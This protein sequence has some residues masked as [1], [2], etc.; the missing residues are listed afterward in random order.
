[1]KRTLEDNVI[2]VCVYTFMII[3]FIVT[4]Y[5]FFYAFIISF[6]DGLDAARGGVYLWPRKFSLENYE[7]IF[8]DKSLIAGFGVTIARTIVGTIISLTFT[9]L[10]AFGLSHNN[11]YFKKAYISM[12]IFAM[13]FS[14]GLI[15][16]FILLRSLGLLDTFWV[17]VIPGMIVPF[18]AIIMMSFFR[19][20]PAALEE[21]ARIDGANDLHIFIKIIVPVSLPVFATIALFAGV[22]HWNSWFD[23]AYFT[24]K[25]S[26]KTASYY[27]KELINKAN[28]TSVSAAGTIQTRAELSQQ[29]FTAE[30]IRMCTLIVVVLPII[31]VY[32]FLQKYFVKGVMIGSVKG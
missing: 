15:P 14:G 32:P 7:A 17:Y 24:Q 18:N 1:M 31:C 6:N 5:P 23:T 21:S 2:D 11:L 22:A 10:F 3:I 13:Y 16:Y 26:L 28:L 4:V 29:T 19:E 9:G 20:I 12:M 25:N 27:L 8:R 30:T